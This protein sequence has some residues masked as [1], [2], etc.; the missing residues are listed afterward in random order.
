MGVE[1]PHTASNDSNDGQYTPNSDS[2]SHNS[3]VDGNGNSGSNSDSNHHNNSNFNNMRNFK[4]NYIASQKK[5]SLDKKVFETS[6]MNRNNLMGKIWGNKDLG[7]DSTG[8]IIYSKKLSYHA[9]CHDK[10]KK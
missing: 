5:E 8:L 2:G 6:D 7:S 4:S 1:T 9:F 10:L 3:N